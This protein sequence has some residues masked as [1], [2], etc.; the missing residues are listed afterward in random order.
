MN[1]YFI[2]FNFGIILH[3]DKII[4]DMYIYICNKVRSIIIY[5]KIKIYGKRNFEII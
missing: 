2:T 3:E 5:R 1:N 4:N